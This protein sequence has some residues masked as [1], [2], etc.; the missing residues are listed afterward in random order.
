[1]SKEPKIESFAD[2]R[3]I[4]KEMYNDIKYIKKMVALLSKLDDK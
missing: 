2:M 3:M 4:I 1:M